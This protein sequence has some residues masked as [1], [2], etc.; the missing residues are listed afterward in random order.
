MISA[1]FS[2]TRRPSSA[3]SIP[4]R[5]RIISAGDGSTSTSYSFFLIA[6]LLPVRMGLFDL[7]AQMRHVAVRI[8][9]SS[10]GAGMSEQVLNRP[11]VRSA[12]QQ[13]RGV[14]MAQHIRK[15][16]ADPRS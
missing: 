5:A 13:V 12:F 11:Q 14:G 9:C 6:F 16:V 15:N 8:N 10:R 4:L 3:L 1:T 2:W 7:L